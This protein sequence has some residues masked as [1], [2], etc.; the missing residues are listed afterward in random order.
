MIARMMGTTTAKMRRFWRKK[1]FG[2]WI[3]CVMT[4]IMR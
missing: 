1:I 3:I 4:D 2:A